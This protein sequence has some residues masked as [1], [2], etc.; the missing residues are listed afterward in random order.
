[1]VTPSKA[2][3][4]KGKRHHFIEFIAS[5]VPSVRVDT[6]GAIGIELRVVDYV[7]EK[8]Q[9]KIATK[10]EK[11]ELEKLIKNL[12]V[13]S[14][15]NKKKG[16]Q[17][18]SSDK[19][20]ESPKV[21]VNNKKEASSNL[22]SEKKEQGDKPDSGNKEGEKD[23]KSNGEKKDENVKSDHHKAPNDSKLEDED[24]ATPKS[25]DDEG[26]TE[27]SKTATEEDEYS[28]SAHDK[29]LNA[30]L[31]ETV[32]GFKPDTTW[33]M[34]AGLDNAK[35]QLQL[36]AEL[37]EKQPALFQGNRKAAQFVLLYGPPGT[38]KGHLAKALCNSVDSTFFMVSASDITSKWIGDSERYV[39]A[40]T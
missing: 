29:T 12:E 39:V 34:V 8:L 7:V 35:L 13:Q 2:P 23:A 15:G 21:Y 10:K 3:A 33:D 36:A 28:R 22:N 1:M 38:G 14:G 26:A 16:A 9:K 31:D 4:H 32:Q 37:P 17:K 24:K 25:S 6:E 5:C 27:K 30:S 19:N 40:H 18:R 11:K 20:S